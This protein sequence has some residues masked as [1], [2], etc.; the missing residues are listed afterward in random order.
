LLA[1][2]PRRR[3]VLALLGVP[4]AD[5]IC[6]EPEVAR[7]LDGEPRGSSEGS[8]VAA[9]DNDDVGNDVVRWGDLGVAIVPSEFE[10]LE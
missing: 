9:S 2:K 7:I 4:S 8:H 6:G 1:E 5:V 10:Q 3:A